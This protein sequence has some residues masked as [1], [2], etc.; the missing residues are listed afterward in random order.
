MTEITIKIGTP[1]RFVVGTTINFTNFEFHM[2]D[3]DKG[4]CSFI[5]HILDKDHTYCSDLMAETTGM[6]DMFDQKFSK[7]NLLTD[8]ES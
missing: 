1:D 6:L 8:K 2:F 3:K 5:K 7:S 4:R